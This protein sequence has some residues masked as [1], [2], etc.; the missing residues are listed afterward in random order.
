[1]KKDN[2]WRAFGPRAADEQCRTI[3]S[4]TL[5]NEILEHFELPAENAFIQ[6]LRLIHK[7]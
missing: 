3:A 1:M 5:F 2:R 7:Y 6:Y 4:D